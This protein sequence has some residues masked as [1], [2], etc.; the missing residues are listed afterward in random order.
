M[1]AL[2]P[3]YF[4]RYYLTFHKTMREPGPLPF[5]WRNYIAILAASR[6]NCQYLVS[7]QEQEFLL[8]DGDS[9]WLQGVTNAAVPRKISNLLPIISMLAHQPWLLTKDHIAPLV[10]GAD[11]WSISEL[12][13]AMLLICTYISMSGFVFG[14]GITPEIDIPE[15]H[16]S[17]LCVGEDEP[18]YEENTSTINADTAKVTELLMKGSSGGEDEVQV[19]DRENDFVNAGS[20]CGPQPDAI[21]AEPKLSRYI[22]GYIM[23]HTDFNVSAKNYAIFRAQEYS[24]KEHG[25]ELVRRFYPDIADVLDEEFDHT[26]TMTYNTFNTNTD[27]DT[28]PFRRAIWYYVQRV[29][30]MFHDDYNYQEVNLFLNR[31]IK[32]FVKKMVCYPDTITNGDFCNLG[33]A[34]LPEEKCHIAILALESHKQAALLYGLHSVMLYI[35]RY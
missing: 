28:L 6:F 12:V 26:Y 19:V 18:K 23:S 22:G 35:N 34:L 3:S 21:L 5:H 9:R 15:Q 8:N 33:L 17:S 16:T 30:G 27:I 29:K 14:C 32:F 20:D 24:W 1:L 7:L 31:S 10:K 13:H 2:H 11:A 25:Y 4:E